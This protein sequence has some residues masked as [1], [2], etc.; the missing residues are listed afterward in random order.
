MARSYSNIG[1]QIGVE[2][3]AGV[4]APA[5]K[6]LMGLTLNPH[7]AFETVQHRPSG[8]KV[9]T[10]SSVTSEKTEADFDG[11]IDYKNI[12]YPLSSLFGEAISTQPDA[13][14]AADVYEHVW[15]FTGK[16]AVSPKTFTVEVGEPNHASKFNYAAFT[17]MDLSVARTGDNTMSGSMVGQALQV[18]D[19]MTPDATEIAIVPVNG[20]HWDV[21]ADADSANIGTSQLESLYE[22][23]LNFGDML[24]EEF[25]INSANKSFTSLYD[26]E[27]P[28]L[29]WNMMLGADATAEAYFNTLRNGQKTFIRLQATGPQLAEGYTYG[30]EVDMCVIVTEFDSY[31]SNDGLYVLPI[32]FALAYDPTWGKSMTIKVTNDLAGL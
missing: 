24:S 20:D 18:G 26:S 2:S 4:E 29:E 15:T 13:E 7:A 22:A 25:T 16:G 1:V 11:P 8:Y 10:V 31:E 5:D 21:F 30:I 14:T 28:S 6:R 17:S 9:A 32:N 19:A 12:I 3:S 23:G 27:E